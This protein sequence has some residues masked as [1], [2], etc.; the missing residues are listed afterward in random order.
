MKALISF[1]YV[2]LVLRL[3]RLRKDNN[4]N[5]YKTFTKDLKEKNY[6]GSKST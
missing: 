3:I 2:M 5:Y 4:I 1:A 6:L